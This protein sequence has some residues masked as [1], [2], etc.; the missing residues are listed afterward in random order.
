M[1]EDKNIKFNHFN[2]IIFQEEDVVLFHIKN[3]KVFILSI[4]AT[5]E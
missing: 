2:N 5:K 1:L 4:L 3:N